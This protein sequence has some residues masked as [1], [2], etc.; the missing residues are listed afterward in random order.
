MK[1]SVFLVLAFCLTVIFSVLVFLGLNPDVHSIESEDGILELSGQ[2]RASEAVSIDV[3]D[4]AGGSVLF[5][6][7]YHVSPQ[8]LAGSVTLTFHSG[9]FAHPITTSGDAVYWY[10]EDAMMWTQLSGT[11]TEDGSIVVAPDHLGYFSLGAAQTISAPVFTKLVD[12][13]ESRAPAEAVRYEIIAGYS[14]SGEPMIQIPGI[15]RAN[16]CVGIP[17][18]GERL[19]RSMQST[20]A[21][22]TVNDEVKTVELSYV[23]HWFL[24]HGAVCALD[25]LEP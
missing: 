24:A 4:P 9:W 13:L 6:S 16:A 1:R 17:T 20:Q 2:Y 10:D 23:A 19:E 21:Q 7:V 18:T 22:I 11:A 5:G 12:E 25:R 14:L 15:V 8:E 3:Q